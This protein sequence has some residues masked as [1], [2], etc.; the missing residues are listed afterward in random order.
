MKQLT[1]HITLTAMFLALGLLLPILFHGIGLGAIFLPMFWPV[2]LGAFFLPLPYAVALGL[3]TPFLSSLLTGMPPLSPPI[4]YLMMAELVTLNLSLALLHQRTRWGVF[5]ILLLGLAVSR[6]ML[7]FLISL[8]APWLGLPS[9]PLS[10]AA[11]AQSLP[12]ILL[13]LFFIPL[14]VARLKKETLFL[15]R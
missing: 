10:I 7:V 14:T 8:A 13:I 5:W 11:A 12:G 4:V 2:A 3:L 15:H 1:R 9:S 6:V